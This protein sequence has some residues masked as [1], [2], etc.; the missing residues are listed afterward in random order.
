MPE[1]C[2]EYE[3]VGTGTA[4]ENIVWSANQG[5]GAAAGI[6]RLT[7][8][9]SI[10]HQ[11]DIPIV[12]E[13][14][15]ETALKRFHRRAGARHPAHVANIGDV[16]AVVVGIPGGVVTTRILPCTLIPARRLLRTDRRP[17]AKITGGKIRA[18]K[19]QR[20]T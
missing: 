3:C 10:Q 19:L 11:T 4:I 2:R 15:L 18:A 5:R 13:V 12:I 16:V 17:G 6:Q 8:R 9:A 14:L 1:V 7:T 20:G